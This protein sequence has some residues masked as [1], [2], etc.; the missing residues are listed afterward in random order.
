M[1]LYIICQSI[2]KC[3]AVALRRTHF[4]LFIPGIKIFYENRK[5]KSQMHYIH[6]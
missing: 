5:K 1:S 3:N 4:G 2:V 6:S